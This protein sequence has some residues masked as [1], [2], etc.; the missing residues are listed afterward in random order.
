MS[1]RP[2]PAAVVALAVFSVFALGV[3]WLYFTGSNRMTPL[4]LG[5]KLFGWVLPVGALAAFVAGGVLDRLA[6]RGGGF[7]LRLLTG[8]ALTLVVLLAGGLIVPGLRSRVVTLIE[9]ALLVVSAISLGCFLL[10]RLRFRPACGAEGLALGGALGLAALATVFFLLGQVGLFRGWVLGI[11]TLAALPLGL[12]P[13]G[14]LAERLFSSAGRL[15]RG[16]GLAGCTLLVLMLILYLVR[17]LHCFS[18]PTMGPADY[19]ALEYHLAAPLEWLRGGFVSFLPHN[20]YANMPAAAEMLYAP[21][22]AL[23]P[24][25]WGGLHFSRLVNLCS[26]ELATLAVFAG[27][28]RLAGRRPAL[29]AAAIFFCGTWLADLTVSPYVEPVLLLFITAGWVAT[30]A[31]VSRGRLDLRR[32]QTAGLLAGAACA[33]KY[34]ALVLVAGP[35][36]L[37]VLAAGLALRQKPAKA[38]TAAVAVGALALCVAAPWY[39]RN[40]VSGGNPVY[41]LAGSVFSSPHWDE[42]KDERWTKAHSPKA[43]PARALWNVAAGRKGAGW[44]NVRSGPLLVVFLPLAA[45]GVWR[46]RRRGAVPIALLTLTFIALWASITHQ[47]ERFLYPAY[48]GLAVLAAVGAAQLPR[49]YAGTLASGVVLLGAMACAPAQY[50]YVRWARTPAKMPSPPCTVMLGLADEEEYLNFG[51]W[52]VINDVNRLPAGSRVLLVGEARSALFTVPTSYATVWDTHPLAA[53]LASSADAAEAA[54]RLGKAGVTHFLWAWP[55]YKRLK[56]SYGGYLPLD[57][58]ARERLRRLER[59]EMR[60]VGAWGGSYGRSPLT[61]RP[62]AVVELWELKP[63]TG[64]L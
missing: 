33:A 6:R 46:R 23:A 15:L 26:S 13:A 10:E 20:A 31:A 45:W 3:G 48:G 44:E 34:P 35:L 42:G 53:A 63:E 5:A 57:D 32:L 8:L 27:A 56:K 21:G 59:D 61:G 16:A 25:R 54:D 19:D 55:E 11:V 47:V 39:L 4:V 29:L 37:A 62:I 24:G 12:R 2:R 7:P 38:V 9:A 36:V 18:P 14:D 50:W 17:L 49:R 43:N 41:P 30:T 52:Q 40:W 22:L 60:R 51:Y 58:A 1:D 64:D 28:R